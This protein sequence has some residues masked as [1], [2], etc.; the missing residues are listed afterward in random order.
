METLEQEFSK[1][2][3]VHKL[4]TCMAIISTH[5][6]E[7][8]EKK[9]S[10]PVFLLKDQIQQETLSRIADAVN[11]NRFNELYAECWEELSQYD[12]IK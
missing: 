2:L 4:A 1:R 7:E 5:L 9:V 12:F 11:Q 3:Q 8:C 10:L 6:E